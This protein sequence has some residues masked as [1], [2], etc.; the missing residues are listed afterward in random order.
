M[1]SL[2]TSLDNYLVLRDGKRVMFINDNKVL[3]QTE[4]SIDVDCTENAAI[5]T[6]A[7]DVI[8]DTFNEVMKH[9]IK[10]LDETYDSISPDCVLSV[11][12]TNDIICISSYGKLKKVYL[13]HFNEIKNELV[14]KTI[15]KH[16][17]QFVDI[18]MQNDH[19]IVDLNQSIHIY[20]LD[21]IKINNISN[22]IVINKKLQL[23]CISSNNKYFIFASNKGPHQIFV[24]KLDDEVKQIARLKLIE[25]IECLVSYD[26]YISMVDKSCKNIL[27]FEIIDETI[28]YFN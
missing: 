1:I 27:T 22:P 13:L 23:Y 7:N 4:M 5:I 2:I 18:K 6:G 3:I 16:N 19:L 26:K 11:S 24:Y 14:V 17:E 15:L 12:V 21:D 28:K 8:N 9:L 25:K 20:K 10:V